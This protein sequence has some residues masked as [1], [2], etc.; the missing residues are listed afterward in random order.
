ML[1]EKDIILE[2]RGTVT[3]ETI[4]P[5]LDKL[6]KQSDFIKLRRGFQKKL[7]SVFVE[8]IEN[9]YKYEANDVD[10][11]DNKEPLSV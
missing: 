3:F 4:D 10:Q 8:C 6:K 9:I 5:L 2:Y 1:S 7:Y 11:F